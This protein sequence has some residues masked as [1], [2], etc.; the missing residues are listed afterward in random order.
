MREMAQQMNRRVVANVTLSLD[1]RV[2]GPGGD[3]DMGWIVPHAVSDTARDHMIR[4]TSPATTSLLGRKNHD[5][6]I[7]YWPTVADQDDADPRDREFSRWLTT[8]EKVVFSTTI[9]ESSWENTIVTARPPADVVAELR[10]R[11]GADIVVL[12]SISIV[13]QLL[14]ADQV[15][16][17]SIV[18]CPEIVGGGTRLFDEESPVPANGWVLVDATTGETGALCLIY[19]RR[20]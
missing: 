9:D 1:G 8:T 16:R 5:G 19:D 10:T 4:V 3:F 7:G 14:A 12:S 15:D 13:R 2:N 6:F 20:R 17:L 18:L 11:P